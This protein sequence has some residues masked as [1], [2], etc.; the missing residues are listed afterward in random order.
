MDGVAGI[1]MRRA[2]AVVSVVALLV[3]SMTGVASAA[4]SIRPDNQPTPIAN[5]ENGEL[6]GD[7][8][9]SVAPDCLAA[10][11]AAPSLGLLLAAGRE[12]GVAL[13]TSE[14]YRPLAGQVAVSQSWTAAGNSACAA[15]V[16]ST[17]SGTPKGTSMHGWG[18]AVDVSEPNNVSFTSPG[19]TFLK[20]HAAQYGWNHPGW[21]EPGGSVCPEAWHWEWVG[22]GG[23]THGDPIRADV[24]AL[25]PTLHDDGYTTVTGLG[26]AIQRGA[27]AD[28]GS[29]AS[30]PLNW[31]VVGGTR[32]PSGGGYW[33]V[34][35]DGG[36]FGFGDAKFFG[37]TGGMKLN[38]QVVGMAP[39]A[40][41]AGYWLV[42]SDGGVF[43]FGSAKFFGST[44]G[45]HLQAPIVGIVPTPTGAGYWLVASDGGVFSF[46]DARFLGSMGSTRLQQPVIGM[47]ATPDG[48]GYWMVASDG[49]MFSFGT[50]RYAGSM[51]GTA[52]SAPI[53]GM[54]PTHAGDGYWLVGADGGIF[55]F[56]AAKFYGAG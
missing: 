23:V 43:T 12:S 34:G 24:V 38:D 19:Y 31:L 52:L 42:A 21:A 27:A 28:Q 18:K 17:P 10:R 35:A 46:G 36:V 1:S 55:T 4:T 11:Q 53:V 25:L 3:L 22:D 32:T 45:L 54:A 16:S 41:G 2:S 15:P 33:M 56:G 8:L 30:L 5:Q 40:D 48:K 13:G 51:G 20:A 50:A 39:S 14:C 49:G 37:S 44:G 9:I 7:L 47:A 29:A 26:G 6:P